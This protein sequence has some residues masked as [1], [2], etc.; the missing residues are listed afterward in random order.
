MNIPLLLATSLVAQANADLMI[1]AVVDGPNASHT[2]GVELYATTDIPD[3]AAYKIAIEANSNSGSYS[4]DV[5]LA[6]GSLTAGSYY[7]VSNGDSAE[8]ETY[9]GFAPNQS[10]SNLN[11]NGDDR[12]VL[13]DSNTE[14]ILDIYGQQGVD[15]S[16]KDWEYTDGWAVR[17]YKT[18]PSPVFYSAEWHYSGKDALDNTTEEPGIPVFGANIPAPV[19]GMC[20]D[21]ATKISTIQGNSATSTEHGNYHVVE[22]VVHQMVDGYKGFFVQEEAS[23]VDVDVATSEGIFV[24][25][26]SVYDS[27]V[28]DNSLQV[29]SQVRLVAEVVESDGI[30]KL[31]YLAD[32][33]N[34]GTVAVPAVVQVSFPV[35]SLDV[36][37]SLEGMSISIPQNM[38]VSDF[39]GNGYG[40]QSEGQFVASSELHYQPTALMAPSVESYDAAVEARILDSIIVDDGLILPEPALIP[41]PTSAGFSNTNYFRIGYGLTNLVGALHG[42]DNNYN[43]KLPYTLVPSSTP[44]FNPLDQDRTLEP[45]VD[46]TGNLVVASMNVLNLFNGTEDPSV[47]GGE[48]FYPTSSQANSYNYRGANSEADYLIQR[49]KIVSALKAMDA[50]LIGLMEIEN[51]GFGEGSSIK[52]LVD[53]LNAEMAADMQYQFVNPNTTSGIIGTDAIAVGLLYRPTVLTLEGSAVILDSSNSPTDDAGEVLFLDDKNR[54]SLIQSFMHTET[55]EV[56]TASINHLKSKGSSCSS[57]GDDNLNDGAGNCNLTRTRAVQGLVEFLATNPTNVTS[58]EVLIMGDMNAY[59]K[60]TPITTF[61]SNGL[62]NLKGALDHA[63][64]YSYSGFLGSLDYIMGSSSM[65]DSMLSIDAWHINSVE[66]D[67]FDYDTDLDKY[68]DNDTYASIDPYYSSDHDPI[69]AS[70]LIEAAADSEEPDNSDTDTPD[71]DTDSSN[72]KKKFLG[73]MP[74]WL[75]VFIP[76]LALLRRK[77]ASM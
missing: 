18:A 66:A 63:F 13:L 65:H 72:K 1:T 43:T 19:I 24:S 71:T 26:G 61:E 37:E 8:F 59:A 55:G 16:Y 31:Q 45:T 77:K 30:T 12:Y 6:T 44:M 67:V 53:A 52:A 62:V 38:V 69:I 60:E 11:G 33:E 42:Y 20:G 50:D 7:W 46:R 4:A 76:V 28:T 54:P 41:L 34:C 75:M 29:G 32:I 51:D 5:Q 25:L 15:G 35:E 22:A 36:L 21:P 27:F 39:Y 17:A 14:N 58:D 49:G 57:L 23:D 74:V 48:T 9:F 64:S 10:G 40:F 73:S 70:F 68:R 2:R 47:N 56:L 3:L